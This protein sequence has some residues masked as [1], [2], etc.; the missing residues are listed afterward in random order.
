MALSAQATGLGSGVARP[1]C[2]PVDAASGAGPAQEAG[3]VVA[4]V[5]PTTR[6]AIERD[7]SLGTVPS[8][9]KRVVRAEPGPGADY[10]G[11][12]PSSA[13]TARQVGHA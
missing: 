1:P 12:R 8:L 4:G 13:W 9:L 10:R 7:D 11:P 2:R 5:A 6:K 3:R